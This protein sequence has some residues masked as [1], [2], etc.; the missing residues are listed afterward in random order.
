MLGIY[1][2]FVEARLRLVKHHL[3]F[4]T[5]RL[6]KVFDLVLA[7]VAPDRVERISF[8]LSLQTVLKRQS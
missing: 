8:L 6:Q 3:L 7:T 5:G 4:A 2:A 1:Q